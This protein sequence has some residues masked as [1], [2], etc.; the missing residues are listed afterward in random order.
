[1]MRQ[2]WPMRGAARQPSWRDICEDHACK[3]ADGHC[4]SARPLHMGPSAPQV[5]IAH[6]G[7]RRHAHKRWTP[8]ALAARPSRAWRAASTSRARQAQRR[9]LRS[10]AL[11]SLEARSAVVPTS[12]V[13]SAAPPSPTS[14]VGGSPSCC[15]VSD[16]EPRRVRRDISFRH[17]SGKE[18]AWGRATEEDYGPRLRKKALSVRA[19]G[20]AR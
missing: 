10:H 13:A 11:A 5:A 12:A 18:P 15:E 20:R 9:P 14:S 6:R 17:R 16:A 4:L 3:S 8:R 7:R 1:M 19:L 2:P